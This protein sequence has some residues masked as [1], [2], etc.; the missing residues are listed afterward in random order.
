MSSASG[1]DPRRARDAYQVRLKT[2][3]AMPEESTPHRRGTHSTRE[4]TEWRCDGVERLM[5]RKQSTTPLI[6]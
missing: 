4:R 5:A 3:R 1:I 6:V 2:T